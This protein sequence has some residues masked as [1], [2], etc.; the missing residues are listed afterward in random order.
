MLLIWQQIFTQAIQLAQLVSQWLSATK[1]LRVQDGLGNNVVVRSRHC[2]WTKEILQ[3]FWQLASTSVVLTSWIHRH[4]NS[5]VQINVDRSSKQDLRRYQNSNK[6]QCRRVHRTK[7]AKISYNCRCLR[8]DRC[9]DDLN[10]LGHRR[11]LVL[12]QTIEFVEASPSTA[13]D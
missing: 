6:C 13:L 9:L 11:K 8:F 4:E 3:I 7:W 10:L 2:D 5:T 12:L 1:S